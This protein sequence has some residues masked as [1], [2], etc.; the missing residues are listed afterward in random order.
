MSSLTLNQWG[1]PEIPGI[2]LTNGGLSHI[3]VYIGNG[4]VIHASSPDA[5]VGVILS[6]FGS[7]YWKH[8]H[9]VP[10]SDVFSAGGA[11]I[12]SNA[13]NSN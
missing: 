5:G 3:G 7:G 9:F 4:K 1:I 6:N 2:C 8:W 13:N 10:W 12:L 11:L